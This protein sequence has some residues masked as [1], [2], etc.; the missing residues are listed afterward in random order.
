[1]G[2]SGL[3]RGR[4]RHAAPRRPLAH[5]GLFALALLAGLGVLALFSSSAH[6]TNL[7]DAS[8]TGPT[9][10][11]SS[12][13]LQLATDTFDAANT[14][15]TTIPSNCSS[16]TLPIGASN[17]ASL[18]ASGLALDTAN[19]GTAPVL[20]LSGTTTVFGQSADIL[21]VGQWPDTTSA[22]P[23]FSVIVR[24]TSID[25]TSLVS[26]T[27]SSLDVPLG[28]AWIATTNATSAVSVDPTTLPSSAQTFLASTLAIAPSA[29][30]LRA[31]PATTGPVATALSRMGV[32]AS[33]VELDGTLSAS[34]SGFSWSAPPTASA[35]FDLTASVTLSNAPSTPWIDFNATQTLEVTGSSSGD[36][37]V[38][39]TGNATVT[40][41]SSSTTATASVSLVG[42]G[43]S[44]E[45]DLSVQLGTLPSAFGQ[46]WL[47]L[48]S[49]QVTATISSS[50]FTGAFSASADIGSPA[51]TF[52]VNASI[53][54]SSGLALSL[55]AA[56]PLDA[57]TVAGDLGLT[58][59]N[60]SG[61]PDP[62]VSN[63]V[64][65]LEVTPQGDVTTAFSGTASISI[66]NTPISVDLLVR[67][68]TASKSL[69]VAA[70]LPG[71]Q[72]LNT[73]L[74]LSGSPNLTL[75]ELSIVFSNTGLT[76]DSSALD[77]ATL[78][79]FTPVLCDG[80][81]PCDFSLDVAKGV[82]V[83]ASVTLPTSLTDLLTKV[84]ITTSGP[85]V[86]D[87]QLPLFG[88]TTTT[89]SVHL[90][91]VYPRSA[92]FARIAVSLD[93]AVAQSSVSFSLDGDMTLVVPGSTNGTSCPSGVTAPSG[94]TCIDLSVSAGISAGA[95]GLA[96]DISAQ[97]ASTTGWTLNDPSWLTIYNLAV[98][99]QI[100]AGESGAGLQVGLSGT[101][102][103]GS[104]DLTVSVAL[105]VTANP[106]W[107]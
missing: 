43:T 15:L 24:F 64:I 50:G 95:N 3:L 89:L 104:K 13:V 37:S 22:S 94:D 91:T 48:D 53:D 96:V 36:W 79:Y 93:L 84:G 54:S 12:C 41:D 52:T 2:R 29:V 32:D 57:Q 40:I 39:L 103:V 85:L 14:S 58:W 98:D 47:T 105:K 6:A 107:I 20:T 106:P 44:V 88:N 1:M 16:V 30:T 70:R 71:G 72:S 9:N 78:A 67:A 19:T 56:G 80:S 49:A 75:P 86:L 61:M 26:G 99:V 23:T 83:E 34:V 97:L 27:S 25:L 82:G 42:S 60:L 31:V 63:L 77:P 46:S 65:D 45:L 68:D 87:G 66:N 35:A 21:V 5:L 11:G 59:P 55:S 7:I 102:Q 92:P 33:A 62:S 38:V 8:I 81:T 90:P 100:S 28:T 69:V 101:V 51:T 74:G 10:S 4:G 76:A 17:F 18:T 73:L